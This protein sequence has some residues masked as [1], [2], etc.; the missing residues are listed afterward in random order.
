LNAKI[1]NEGGYGQKHY[2]SEDMDKRQKSINK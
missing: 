2:Y 1:N